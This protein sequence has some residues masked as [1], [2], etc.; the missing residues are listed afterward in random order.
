MD[1]A[2]KQAHLIRELKN[3]VSESSSEVC[4]LR[5]VSLLQEIGG[6]E[7]AM[8]VLTEISDKRGFVWTVNVLTS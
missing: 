4:V 5:L 7:D 3:D 8:G 2:E 6:Y 1:A